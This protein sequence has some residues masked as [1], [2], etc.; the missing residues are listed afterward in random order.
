MKFSILMYFI[1]EQKK[2]MVVDFWVLSKLW[3]TLKFVDYTNEFKYWMERFCPTKFTCKT[4][5]SIEKHKN[6]YNK[7]AFHWK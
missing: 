5:L 3:N 6:K 4:H 7:L 1:Y 2:R